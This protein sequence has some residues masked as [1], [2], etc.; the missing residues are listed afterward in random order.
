MNNLE[1]IRK[2]FSRSIFTKKQAI[3]SL[4]LRNN[5]KSRLLESITDDIRKYSDLTKPSMSKKAKEEAEKIG[6]NLNNCGWHDQSKFDKN[7]KIFHYEHFY[8]V[9]SIREKCLK[10][11]DEIQIEEILKSSTKIIW[12]LKE[13][14]NKLTEL[15]YKNDR[16]DPKLAYSE[17]GIIIL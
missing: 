15:G 17:A 14:D 6:V 11:E 3:D 16:N 7:R 4:Q 13:E 5:E 2:T 10:A 1:Q 12:I 8:T 9:K